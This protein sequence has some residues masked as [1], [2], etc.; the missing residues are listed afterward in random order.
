MLVKAPF[1][2]VYIFWVSF[3][4]AQ[5]STMKMNV[6]VS[7]AHRTGQEARGVGFG[8]RWQASA[9]FRVML[10]HPWLL[11]VKAASESTNT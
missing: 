8:I 5:E 7:S 3:K 10:C 2:L 9:L 6:S 4:S 11:L 1:L